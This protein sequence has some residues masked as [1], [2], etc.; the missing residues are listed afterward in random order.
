MVILSIKLRA[1][2]CIISNNFI[3]FQIDVIKQITYY[4]ISDIALDLKGKKIYK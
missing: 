2:I 3:N 1:M 4:F